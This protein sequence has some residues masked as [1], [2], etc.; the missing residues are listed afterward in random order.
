[1]S[2]WLNSKHFLPSLVDIIREELRGDT[3]EYISQGN[4]FMVKNPPITFSIHI[5]FATCFEVKHMLEG[6][7]YLSMVIAFFQYKNYF[8]AKNIP[9]VAV[10]KT[11]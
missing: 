2:R 3:K 5:L 10:N 7:K 1:M 8:N 9:P 4:S 11:G 6:L